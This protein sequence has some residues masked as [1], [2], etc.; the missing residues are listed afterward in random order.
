MPT[1]RSDLDE[2]ITAKVPFVW[3]TLAGRR[4]VPV[5]P[6]QNQCPVRVRFA[7]DQGDDRWSER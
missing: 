1:G 4:H 5:S 3:I 6:S 7:D 2:V